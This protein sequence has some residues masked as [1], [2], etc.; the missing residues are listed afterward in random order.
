MNQKYMESTQQ[1]LKMATEYVDVSCA[2]IEVEGINYAI[3]SQMGSYY[4]GAYKNEPIAERELITDISSDIM[5][6][7]AFNPFISDIHIITK[8]GI[9]MFS[10][11]ST[12]RMDGCLETYC[13]A[14]NSEKGSIDKWVDRHEGLDEYLSLSEEDLF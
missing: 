2:F 5:S 9:P 1:T 10:T 11:V 8:S 4:M 6:S 7:K 13:E 14:L 3:D 12:I